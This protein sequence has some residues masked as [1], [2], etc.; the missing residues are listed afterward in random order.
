MDTRIGFPGIPIAPDSR[1]LWPVPWDLPNLQRLKDLGFNAIQLNIAWGC[2]PGDEPLN[3]EDLVELSPGLQ[4][5]YPQ[6]VPLLCDPSPA[7]R[8]QRRTDLAQR[9]ALCRE[10]GLRTIFHFGAPYNAHCRY[11]DGPPNCL[12]DEKVIRRYE[13][14]LDQF[15]NEFPG[16][17]DILVY[18]Y[19]QDAWLCSEFGPCPRC[20]GVPLHDRLVPFL[21]RLAATWQNH[22]RSGR[23]W[24]EP[25][26]LSAGQVLECV[27]RI[28]TKGFALALHCNVAE[29]MGTMPVD[30]WLKNTCALARERGIP[31][32]V[33]Y[34]LGGP[35]EE[36]EP[37]INLAHPLV[38]LRG[39]K[40]ISAVPGVCGIKE[41]YGLAPNKGD[42][43]LEMTSLFFGNPA[44]TEE[45][46]LRTLAG[47]YAPVSEEMARF[48]TLCS[49]AM[50]L[51]PW[52][53]SW[54]IR[55]IG[56][57]EPA[58]SMSAAKLRGQQCHTPSWFS[59]RHAIF[60][61]TDDSQ[62]DPW[63]IEDV[64]LRCRL[65]AER[66]K[67]AIRLGETILDRLP[68]SRR[69][70]FENTLADVRSICRRATAYACHLRETNLATMMR[71]CKTEERDIPA[72]LIAQMRSVLTDDLAS[73]LGE[74]E[75]WPEMQEAIALLDTDVNAFL[76]K[77]LLEE[78][79]RASKG[80]F[81]VTSR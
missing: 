31:V 14:L 20:L 3:L 46:A 53:T 23:L 68:E 58:H 79:D 45:E 7:R 26:E 57:S 54:Y 1:F 30:R 66:W 11:G 17:D 16:I 38:T 50:E 76:R 70:E 18:T 28:G 78:P 19:D 56:R 65:A 69:K 47:A 77:F 10:L 59:T 21:D 5:K 64:E 13:L 25:W 37:L 73:C 4:E 2:R 72:G 42:A 12:S 67:E 33:E 48:W 80:H 71:L 32:V 40:A 22:S 41:Y 60:M 61:K 39:L 81:S 52:D 44:I 55:E 35:S 24:W 15:A 6:P 51:F 36:L 34:W 27:M 8:E 62:P 43:N 9:I 75:A 74:R 29:V 63:M 49:R